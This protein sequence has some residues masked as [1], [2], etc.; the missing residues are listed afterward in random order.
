MEIKLRTRTSSVTAEELIEKMAVAAV[1]IDDMTADSGEVRL[2][3]D[4]IPLI[5][6]AWGLTEGQAEA[7]TEAPD[8]EPDDKALSGQADAN[9]VMNMLWALTETS[10]RLE[11]RESREHIAALIG[12]L[13]DFWSL[14]EHLTF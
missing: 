8:C 4:A 14:E 11:R 1:E 3:K 12:Y 5:A 2:F 13:M 6:E 9:T 10:V 7:A